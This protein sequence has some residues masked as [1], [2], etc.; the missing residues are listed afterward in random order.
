MINLMDRVYRIMAM[1]VDIRALL[2]MGLSKVIIVYIL[3][4]MGRCI[5]GRLSMVSCMDMAN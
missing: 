5:W 2:L 4:R 3:G 1:A